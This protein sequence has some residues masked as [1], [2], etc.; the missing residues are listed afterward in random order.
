MSKQ[1]VAYTNLVSCNPCKVVHPKLEEL[2]AEGYDITFKHLQDQRNAFID[3]DVR[4]TPTFII[5][6]DGVEIDRMYGPHT[7]QELIEVLT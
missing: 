6:E 4:S 3:A 5:Y 1:L 2:V 7:K